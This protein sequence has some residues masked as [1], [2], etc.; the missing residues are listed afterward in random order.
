MEKR[1]I[2]N[3]LHPS[4]SCR[5]FVQTG[6]PCR[7]L[8]LLIKDGHISW[9]DLPKD[10]QD[11]PFFSKEGSSLGTWPTLVAPN[12]DGEDEDDEPVSVEEP[13]AAASTQLRPVDRVSN[14]KADMNAVSAYLLE[15][16]ILNLTDNDLVE[17]EREFSNFKQLLLNKMKS[18]TR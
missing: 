4:C 6:F 11:V 9:T 17:L 12:L 18:S 5:S 7:H 1:Y 2:I 10:Y 13:A 3:L 8:F 14:L 16:S 15:D